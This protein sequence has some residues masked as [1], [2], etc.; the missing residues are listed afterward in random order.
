[1]GHRPRN[2]RMPSLNKG[3]WVSGP[4]ARDDNNKQVMFL[5]EPNFLRKRSGGLEPD[6]P[7]NTRQKATILGRISFKERSQR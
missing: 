4:R 5:E 6:H 7:V 1:M 2:P 3:K